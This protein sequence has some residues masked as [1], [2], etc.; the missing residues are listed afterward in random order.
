MKMVFEMVGSPKSEDRS[1]CQFE[2]W[3][4]WGEIWRKA[5]DQR[6][7]D[8]TDKWNFQGNF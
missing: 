7:S 1:K 5:I 4:V 6:I 8:F 2:I 3:P